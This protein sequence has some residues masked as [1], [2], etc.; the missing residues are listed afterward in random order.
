M[1]VSAVDIS[2]G[3]AYLLIRECQKEA[4]SAIAE[5]NIPI[6]AIITDASS[7][8]LVRAHNTQISGCDPSAHAEMNALRVL[9]RM[10]GSRFLDGCVIFS[11]AE[12]C[13]MCAAAAIKACIRHFYY[14][15]SAESSMNPNISLAEVAQASREPLHVVGPLLARS[16]A[17][18]IARGRT[19]IAQKS[20][21]LS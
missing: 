5:G 7:N 9:A 8:I 17:Q 4:E 2:R 16:C 18:Q 15:A 10:R 12:P 1:S 6:A 21:M 20:S 11:N 3:R 13:V 14:G 19:L